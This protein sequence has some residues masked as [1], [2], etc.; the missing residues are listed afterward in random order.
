MAIIG[1]TPFLERMQFFNGERLL[2]SD[3]QGIEAFNREMRWLH[4]RS[5]HQPGV[6]SGFAVVGQK[7]DRQVTIAPGYAVDADGREIILT[8]ITTLAI[9]PVADNGFGGSVFYDLTVSYPNDA[10]LTASETRAGICRT[11]GVVRLREEPVLCWIRLSDDPV[12]RQPVDA[13]QRERIARGEFIVLAEVEIFNCQLKQPVKT[14][15]RPNARP[16]AQPR[17]ACGIE[18]NPHWAPPGGEPLPGDDESTTL[19]FPVK[20]T[21]VVDTSAGR[22]QT[23]PG[24]NARI[25]GP[26]QGVFGEVPFF[27]D[28]LI[29]IV[30]DARPETRSPT[31]RGFRIEIFLLASNDAVDKLIREQWQVAWLGIED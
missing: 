15:V 16:P 9:P 11:G 21:G 22:F 2:A 26:R 14:S 4:N 3:L 10:D 18:T 25:V 29:N 19:L 24:Y 6:G 8:E 30:H 23:T 20:Y 13:R 27:V 1:D 17:I 28:A 12:R 7:G 31:E 5:L